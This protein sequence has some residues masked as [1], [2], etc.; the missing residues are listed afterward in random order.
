MSRLRKD[1]YLDVYLKKGEL[2]RITKGNSVVKKFSL[3]EGVKSLGLS[4]KL[5][6]NGHARKI[7]KYLS[8]PG[9]PK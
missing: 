5:E 8:P 3:P 4:I 6:S 1:P 9:R 7:A 2:G